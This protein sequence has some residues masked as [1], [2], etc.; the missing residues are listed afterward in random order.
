MTIAHGSCEPRSVGTDAA[1][2][3]QI[4]ASGAIALALPSP[5]HDWLAMYEEYE[6]H[7]NGADETP[8]K[9]SGG[10]RIEVSPN[11]R[12]KCKGE[13]QSRRRVADAPRL[14]EVRVLG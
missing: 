10:Y 1:P 5:H 14:V 8:A 7:D 9:R 3:T 4:N 11:N 6:D 12:A 13:F 2:K